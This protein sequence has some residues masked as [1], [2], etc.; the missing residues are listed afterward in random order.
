MDWV[1]AFTAFEATEPRCAVVNSVRASFHFFN[2]KIH[3]LKQRR[4][5]QIRATIRLRISGPRTRYACHLQ[6]NGPSAILTTSNTTT[7]G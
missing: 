2:P 6:R 5:T 1:S 3:A 7:V 4:F